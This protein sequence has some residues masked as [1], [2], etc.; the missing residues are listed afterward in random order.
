MKRTLLTMLKLAAE[1]YGD[2]PYCY[3]KT[4]AGWTPKSFARIHEEAELLATGLY[5]RGLKPEGKA[6]IL[7]EGSPEWVAFEFALLTAGAISVPL[8]IKLLPEE[9][10]F[11]VNHSDATVVAVSW[12]QVEKLA[13]VYKEL[14]KKPLVVLLED[15]DDRLS[16]AR[17][18]LPTAKITSYGELLSEG[19]AAPPEARSQ[20]AEIVDSVGEDTIATISY[21]SGTTGNPKGIML[22]HLNYYV[23]SHDAIEMFEVPP[24]YSTLVILPCDHSFAH[25]VAIYAALNAGISLSFVDARGG[26]VAI[27]RHIPGNMKE[28][29]PVFLLT[30]PALTGNFMKKITHGVS[31]KG[32][33]VERL[34]RAGVSAGIR[35][36]GD[37]CNRPG[38]LTRL[39]TWFPHALAEILIFRTVRKTFGSR[40]QFFVGGGAL[41]DRGQ[42]DFFAAIGVPVYQGYGLTEAAPIISS[43]TPKA[44]KFGTSGRVAPAVTCRITRDDGTEAETG[45]SGEICIRG[46]NVMAGYYKNDKAT[47]ETIVDGWLHTGDLGYMD[48]DGYLVVSGRAKAL[49]I[50]TD[51]EK[52]S[53]E[54]IEE[55]IGTESELIH[56]V[57][58]YNDYCPYTTALVTLDEDRVRARI[59]RE[60]LTTPRQLLAA[61]RESLTSYETKGV[62]F[63][64]QW[65][66]ATF[67]VL[68]EPFT[69][70]NHMINSTMKM[71]RHKITEVYEDDIEYLYTD[72]GHSFDNPRNRERVARLF[73]LTR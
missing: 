47:A 51:G 63:P 57:M 39:V 14:K 53:P 11:R 20:V 7:G 59:K 17:I 64:S 34:F 37:G 13:S 33:F 54:A 65:T 1:T 32:A 61:V 52:Y 9:V 24:D 6:V 73:D 27:L 4:D 49:L 38:I 45:G 40:I 29:N 36:N 41:L 5:L 15:S 70:A 21:T 23:N 35:R 44:H 42:Q 18:A 2:R 8:S 22:T 67:L 72:E 66:P 71:V 68:E 10:P 69:E 55:A 30:V 28:T 43:N 50:S 25:T 12:N 58:V 16:D 48:E 60:G 26:S 62:H 31:E 56:Q 3:R 19:A 46:E